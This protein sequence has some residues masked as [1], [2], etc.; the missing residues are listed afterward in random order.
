M[1]QVM[2]FVEKIATSHK[3][4]ILGA[5]D[6]FDEWLKVNHLVLLLIIREW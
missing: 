1:L 5:E 6:N 4:E 3:E 2:E